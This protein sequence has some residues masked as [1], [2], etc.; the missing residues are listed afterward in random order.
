ML[1]SEFS[2]GRFHGGEATN[3]YVTRYR[4]SDVP[5]LEALGPLDLFPSQ[6]A[7]G[8]ITPPFT[9]ENPWPF[10][11]RAGVYFVYSAS[12]DLLYVGS[13]QRLGARLS[14]HFTAGHE[15]VIWETWSQPP[16]YI[17]NVAVPVDM[18]FEAPALELYLIRTLQP[19][20]NTHG[21]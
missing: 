1:L 16:R 10:G 8:D 9:W 14:Y 3:E 13:S 21:K 17:I 4:R 11:D 18:P 5:P 6:P 15:C 12:F 20:D 7:L 19:P 2:F